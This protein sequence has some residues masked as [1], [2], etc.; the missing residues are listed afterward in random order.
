VTALHRLSTRRHEHATGLPEPVTGQGNSELER[1]RRAVILIHGFANS[2][3]AASDS[4]RELLSGLRDVFWPQPPEHFAEF[5][6]FHWPG[7]HPSPVHRFASYPARVPV[8]QAAGERLA[9]RLATLRPGTEVILVAHS[10]GCRVLLTAL[11]QLPG[12]PVGRRARVSAA[13]L[14]AAAVPVVE[15]DPS[16]RGRFHE[17]LLDVRRYVVLHSR[18]DLV[19]ALLF[20]RGQHQFDPETADEAVGRAGRPEHGRWTAR[21]PTGLGHLDYWRSSAAAGQ[22]GRAISPFGLHQLPLRP[23]PAGT[24]QPARRLPERERA[25]RKLP[26]HRRGLTRWLVR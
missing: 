20:K 4:Y 22:V 17:R 16:R 1:T 24:G 10:L 26:V 19:L 2:E 13:I 15:C 18:R 14:L 6:A 8:A 23:E 7:D 25:S 5:F 21:I 12:R 3:A 11:A 9:D